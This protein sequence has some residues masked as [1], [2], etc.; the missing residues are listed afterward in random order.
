MDFNRE[1]QPDLDQQFGGTSLVN[2]AFVCTTRGV[3]FFSYHVSAKSRLCLKLMK[4]NDSHMI[5]CDSADGF[6]VTSGSAVMELNAGDTVSL[7]TH[8]Y[9]SV[10]TSTSSTSHTFTGF[11]LFPTA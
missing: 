10:V 2:G 4:G 5:M 3:Y 6:L 9:S 1:I 7:Q 11:L 8:R